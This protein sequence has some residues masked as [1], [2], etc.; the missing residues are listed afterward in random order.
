MWTIFEEGGSGYEQQEEFLGSLLLVLSDRTASTLFVLLLLVGA[1]A[2]PSTPEV[3]IGMTIKTDKSCWTC[4]YLDN[5]TGSTF[6]QD[7]TCTW[8]P[9]HGKG[10]AK[11]LWPKKDPEEGCKFWEKRGPC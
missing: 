11:Q 5:W 4:K 1:S 8:F 7:F 10:P 3:R 2:H 6:V 9:K